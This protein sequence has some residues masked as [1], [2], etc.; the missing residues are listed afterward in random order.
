MNVRDSYSSSLNES[1]MVEKT[2]NKEDLMRNLMPSQKMAFFKMKSQE[3]Q[4]ID[5]QL[6]KHSRSQSNVALPVAMGGA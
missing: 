6:S 5:N 1:I 3:E 2:A 4:H